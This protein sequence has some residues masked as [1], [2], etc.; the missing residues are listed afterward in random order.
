MFLPNYFEILVQNEFQFEEIQNF[1]AGKNVS[2]YFSLTLTFYLFVV[3][4]TPFYNPYS[5]IVLVPQFN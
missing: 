1:V 2:L 4:N 3:K 5:Y